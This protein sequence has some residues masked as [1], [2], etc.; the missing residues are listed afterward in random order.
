M[1]AYVGTSGY[2]YK[3][4]KGKFY[5][6]DLPADQMLRHY[7]E[8]LRTVEINNTF[9]RM[10]AESVLD[11]WNAQVPDGFSFVLKAPRRIT[12][13]GRL[14]DVGDPVGFFLERANRLAG[15]LG[16]LLFQLPPYFKKDIER[17]EA[18]TGLLPEGRRVAVE[19]R[20][21]SWFDDAVYEILRSANVALC[22]ADGELKGGAPPFVATADWGYLRLRRVEYDD[23]ALAVLANTILKQSWSEVYVF[24]KHEDDA[25]GPA[26][27]ARFTEMLEERR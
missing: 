21:L 13:M 4:W 1:E 11:R 19:F 20:H 16:P 15:K 27:A 5:P 3:E 25:A 23:G 18:F 14:K 22:V 17:L 6:D 12:H 2:A 9:Y 8:R 24:F 10:P 7:A 26:M